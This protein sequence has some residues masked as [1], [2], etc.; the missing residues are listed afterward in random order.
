MF[1]SGKNLLLNAMSWKRGDQTTLNPV[2]T[3]EIVLSL[4]LVLIVKPYFLPE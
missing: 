3:G 2:L 4:W 1:H